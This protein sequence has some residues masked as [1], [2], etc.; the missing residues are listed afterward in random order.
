MP[1]LGRRVLLAGH[2][3]LV[4]KFL[5]KIIVSNQQVVEQFFSD[6]FDVLCI[7]NLEEEVKGF[8]FNYQVMVLQ[9]ISYSR[10]M[11]LNS[12]IVD[13]NDTLE[14]LKGYESDIIF[15]IHEE[16][17]QDID[18]QH[19]KPCACLYS[20]DGSDTFG[21]DRVPWILGSLCIG[22]NLGQNVTHLI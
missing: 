21:E 11:S 5:H 3:Y 12:I 20:H 1:F 8:L 2:A 22:R 7:S 14:T 4:G 15:F 9:T 10:L 18:A 6:G 17:A 19:T 16:A 13:V